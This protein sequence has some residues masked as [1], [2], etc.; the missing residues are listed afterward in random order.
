M[1]T[2]SIFWG[3]LFVVAGSLLMLSNLGILSINMW[4]LVWPTFI[5]ALGAWT[6]WTA[7]QGKGAL[8]IEEI[9]IPLQGAESAKI[10]LEFGAGQVNLAG[11][12]GSDQFLEGT[13]AGGAL[14]HSK[15]IE[16]LLD[17]TIEPPSADFVH[18]VM[19]WSWGA[20]EWNISLN[21]QIPLNLQVKT[22][23]SSME[24]DLSN[25][26]VTELEL[27]TGASSTKI[28]LPANAGHTH[29]DVD[30]GAASIVLNVP[31]GVAARIQID[32]G[33]A[34]ISVDQERFPRLGDI[35]KSNE[36]DT[37][38]NKVDITADFGAGSLTIR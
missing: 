20:R 35:Y 27:D 12:A 4:K 2:K 3:G 30:G 17:V 37:A 24:L 31:D 21:D 34:A 26:R 16:N 13:F 29:V 11:G 8:E 9:S 14:T 25:L 1:K 32:S 10:Q 33:L 18:M 6:L 7:T 19:P 23:A 5:I 38:E 28:T 36:F 15:L 22:G